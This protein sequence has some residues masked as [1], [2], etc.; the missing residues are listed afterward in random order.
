VGNAA[1]NV[2]D[3]TARLRGRASMARRPDAMVELPTDNAE[4]VLRTVEL[5]ETCRSDAAGRS[6]YYRQMHQIVETGRNDGSRSLINMLYSMLDRLSSHLCSPAELRFGMDFE[7]E[8]PE[9]IQRRGAVAARL[10]QHAWERRNTD[11]LFARGVFDSLKYGAAIMK[12]WPQHLGADRIPTY[13]SSLVMPWQFAV[14][15]PEMDSLSEQPAMV[16]T[17]MLSLPQVWRR[18][19]HMPDARRLYD[20]IKQHASPNNATD[21]QTGPFHQILSTSKLNAAAGNTSRPVPG[22]IVQLG[23]EANYGGVPGGAK[24]P[25]VKMHE[26]WVWD[27]ADY[28]TIQVIEPDILIAPLWRRVNLLVPG[29]D[30][31]LHPFTLIQPNQTTGNIWGRSEIADL[32]EPQDFLS[33]T[34]ND[35]RRLF[36]VQVDK[37]LA[38][39]GDGLTDEQYDAMRGAG[40]TNLGPGGSVQDLTPKFPP[41]ALPLVDKIIQLM[42]MIAGF[43]NLLSGRG[44]PGVRSGEQSNP[45]MKAAGA[46]LKDRSLI[47]ERQMNE[48]ADL[49]LSLMEAKDG[50]RYWTNKDKIVETQFLLSDLPDDRRPVVDGHTSS[51]IF[52]DDHQSLLIGG[53]KLG[54]VDSESAVEQLPFQNRDAILARMK[55][56]QA[57]EAEMVEQLKKMDPE[58]WAKMIVA[59]VGGPRK[60]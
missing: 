11:I 35:I 24:A 1:E 44:E 15:Q 60:K 19:Y 59:T 27:G 21:V 12:Q 47:V 54:L 50:R 29:L 45:M 41:E 40:Y 52:S 32:I 16:E 26:C 39:T 46:R 30:T 5:I 13:H 48:A 6:A 43:D 38:F 18:I 3:I 14:Y 7:N 17:V 37:I 22:G 53:V 57:H 10:I 58:S 8:Y 42:E 2:I 23:A 25:M 4:L 56:R 49:T 31:G 34:A 28:T 36:G 20:R 9:E 55:T 51:P 33:T